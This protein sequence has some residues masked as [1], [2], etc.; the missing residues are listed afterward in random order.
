MLFPNIKKRKTK[1]PISVSKRESFIQSNLKNQLEPLNLESYYKQKSAQESTK[2]KKQDRNSKNKLKNFFEI[3]KTIEMITY[4]LDTHGISWIGDFAVKL[5]KLVPI[6]IGVSHDR[7]GNS[8]IA[9]GCDQIKA[10]L[11]TDETYHVE[12]KGPNELPI[13][14][15]LKAHEYTN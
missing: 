2:I 8:Y 1:T 11:K 3:V 14:K 5:A 13:L 12:I 7:N 9:F 15:L 10:C 6:S 4:V